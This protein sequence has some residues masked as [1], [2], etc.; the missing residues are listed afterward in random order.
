MG[1]GVAAF[2]LACYLSVLCLANIALAQ[3][4]TTNSTLAQQATA[5]YSQ[6]AQTVIVVA[7]VAMI[8]AFLLLSRH[9]QDDDYLSDGQAE[10]S[11]G[12]SGGGA[13]LPHNDY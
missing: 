2:L 9:R 3:D 7:I 12:G 13:N 4:S 8:I 1:R 5:P 10:S 6:L 11:G